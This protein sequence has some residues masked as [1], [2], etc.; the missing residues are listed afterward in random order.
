MAIPAVGNVVRGGRKSSGGRGG[1]GAVLLAKEAAFEPVEEGAV[2]LLAAV[3][4]GI[5]GE[6]LEPRDELVATGRILLAGDLAALEELRGATD[7]VGGLVEGNS[8]AGG[9]R[10]GFCLLQ[11]PGQTITTVAF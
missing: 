4:K 5:E 8:Q 10:L 3:L 11:K 7:V 2:G 6:E 9:Q 1:F